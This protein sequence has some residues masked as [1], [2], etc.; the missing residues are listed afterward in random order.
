MSKSFFLDRR[1]EEYVAAHTPVGDPLLRRLVQETAQLT[2]ERAQQQVPPEQG[3]LLE[4]LCRLS[5]AR[6]AVELGTFTGYSSICLA[7]GLGPHGQLL[8]CDVSREWTDV[9]R[10]YWVDA[11]VDDRVELH[12]LPAQ[13]FL[14][15]LPT[16]AS[17]D[18]AFVDADKE[19]YLE[20]YQQLL[21]RLRPGGLLVF[22]NVLW[23]GRVLD[24]HDSHPWTASIAAFNDAVLDDRRVDVVM[25]P[26]A[27]GVTL[28]RRRE[29]ARR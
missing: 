19:H 17:F 24:P 28:L 26:F 5:G 10:R 6:R 18:L 11:G 13:E 27:D 20:S 16:E 22:D 8:T 23:G 21:P 29:D 1:V 15:G 3:A 4:L 9:A 7:R 14:R 12:L 25:L 2:G